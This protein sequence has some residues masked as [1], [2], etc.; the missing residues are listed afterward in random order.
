MC[1]NEQNGRVTPL[2]T[3]D[4]VAMWGY[5]GYELD[6]TKLNDDEKEEV[7]K[8]IT[9]YKQIRKLTQFGTL[10]RLKSPFNSNQ[11]AWE[12][13]SSDKRD[14]ILTVVNILSSAQPSFTKPKLAGLNPEYD[15]KNI[16]TNE[17]IGGD[18]LMD[19]GIYDEVAH[20]DFVAKMY[21]F[22]AV[23]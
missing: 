8:Q 14:V 3:R 10:Y 17:I 5:L 12:V 9:L 1:P 20:Q 21:H 4:A 19:T 23:N 18:E 2:A 7:K 13:V 16:A 6:L 22:K 11:T 15:Y